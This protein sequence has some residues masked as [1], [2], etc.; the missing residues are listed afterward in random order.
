M[1]VSEKEKKQARR[2]SLPDSQAQRVGNFLRT[3]RGQG[4]AIIILAGLILVLFANSRNQHA[5]KKESTQAALSVDQLLSND[6]V[7]VNDSTVSGSSDGKA[8]L[9]SLDA[10]LKSWTYSFVGGGL[11]QVH[12]TIRVPQEVAIIQKAIDGAQ[13]GDTVFVSAGEYKEN[14]VMKDGVSVV[15]ES[16]AAVIL[17]GDHQGNVVTF[18]DISD[19]NT[20]LENVTVRNAG[21]SL[22]GIVIEDSSP[23]INR[24]LLRQND[25]NIYIKGESSPTIQRNAISESKVGVQIFNLSE[26]LTAHASVSDN[27]IFANKKGINIYKGGAAVTHNT[28]S[29]NGYGSDGAVFGIY[30]ASASAELTNNIITDNGNCELCSGIYADADVHDASIDSNDLWNNASNFVCFGKCAMGSKNLSEDPGF[31]NGFQYDF[32]LRSDSP[33]LGAATDGGKLGARL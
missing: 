29:Y 21:D 11:T 4:M 25:Y 6:R 2:K 26:P 19:K 24:N 5:E 22:S 8:L 23:L 3:K 20:R 31:V 27:L 18:R 15:G 1:E 30:L 17:N 33:L 16:A 32:S 13:S 9:E 14:L 12:K 7:N 28:I 10:G